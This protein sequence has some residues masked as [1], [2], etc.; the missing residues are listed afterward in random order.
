MMYSRSATSAAC[1]LLLAGALSPGLAAAIDKLSAPSASAAA[2]VPTLMLASVWRAGQDPSG[3][4]VSE[5]LDGVRAFWDG[6]TLR[7]RSGRAIAAPSWFTAALP[8][9]AL[10]GELWLGRGRFDELSGLVRRVAPMD[11]DWHQ[12]QYMIFDLPKATEPFSERA[13]HIQTLVAQAR[14][15]WLQAVPQQRVADAHSLQTLLKATV[16]AGGEGLV[17]HRANA[18]WAP[19]RSD[20]LL[21]L[22]LQPDEDAR[23]V[24]HLPG[25][26]RHAGRLGALS[27]EMPDGQRFALGTGF[28]DA[29]RDNPPAVGSVVTYR[30]RDRTPKG[31]PRFASFLRVRPPE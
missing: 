25:K 22:K 20:A 28:T 31:L 8:Q 2:S 6:Q 3:F 21:K 18:L 23:V 30:F 24:A 4:L 10:D 15:P 1:L 14:Q 17:L 26:G 9:T 29:Q 19:G 16:Q 13:Q 5:K 11:A 27:L 7:F 12:V